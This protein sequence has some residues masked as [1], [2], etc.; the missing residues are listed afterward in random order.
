MQPNSHQ[1]QIEK[2]FPYDY[3]TAMKYTGRNSFNSWSTSD[4]DRKKQYLIW[5]PIII[6]LSIVIGV[7]LDQWDGNI[8]LP[9]LGILFLGWILLLLWVGH[10][11]SYPHK[12]K[13]A[14]TTV[15]VLTKQHGI[16]KI[17]GNHVKIGQALAILIGTQAVAHTMF[18]GVRTARHAASGAAVAA[19]A[20][21]AAER[22]MKLFK[23]LKNPENIDHILNQP[24]L[25]RELY[26]VKIEKTLSLTEKPKYY[27]GK[28]ILTNCITHK[29]TT[30]NLDIG[31]AY[32]DFPELIHLLKQKSA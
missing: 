31:K 23:Y 25:M 17:F 29:T 11:A 4:K 21:A 9:A 30:E 32:K 8:P 27:H 1:I 26:V 14:V 3:E 24:D 18:G 28:F 7:Y 5:V 6:L 10:R 19:T 22:Q 16:Y 2:I 20:I 12:Y 15:Y 13:Y